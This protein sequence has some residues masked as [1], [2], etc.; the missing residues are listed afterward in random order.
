MGPLMT[1]RE[2]LTWLYICPSAEPLT[3]SKR[4]ARKT[5]FVAV[6]VGHVCGFAIHVAYVFKI[7]L[8]N[9]EG[10]IYAFMGAV[11]FFSSGYILVTVF[12][13]RHQIGVILEQL[14]SIYETR[15]VFSLT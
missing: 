6:C 9:L 8:S 15:K 1:N 2:A 13:F 11:A 14:S 12:V 5:F 10:S 4:N 7:G 3:K